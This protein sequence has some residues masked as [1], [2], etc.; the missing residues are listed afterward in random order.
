M[1]LTALLATIVAAALALLATSLPAATAAGGCSSGTHGSPGYAYAGHQ[2]TTVANGVRA[3]ITATR[4]PTVASGHVAGWIGVGG[5][6][7]GQNGE[8][9]WLQ[10]GVAGIPGMGLVVYAEITRSGLDPVFVPLAQDVRVGQR[11]SLAVLEMA[12][13]PEHWRVWLD[14]QPVTDPIYLPGS[15]RQWKPIATAE[16]NRTDPGACNVLG[17]RFER[18]RVAGAR[19]G[20]WRTFVPGYRFLDRGFTIKQLRPSSPGQRTL[21]SDSVAPFAFEASSG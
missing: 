15:T 10:T 6:N 12:R 19:G 7:Q 3:T 9:M 16:S 18:V 13:Q 21:A 2:A 11:F 20:S 4:R 14:G 5:P 8:T 17:F 1:K